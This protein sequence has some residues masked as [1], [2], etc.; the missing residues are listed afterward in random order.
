MISIINQAIMKLND[1]HLLGFYGELFATAAIAWIAF[2]L[3]QQRVAPAILFPLAIGGALGGV[4]LVLRHFTRV[5]RR[6]IAILSAIV[7]GL[8]LVVAQDYVGLRHRIRLFENE[9]AE[10]HPLAASMAKDRELRPT[11]IEHVTKHVNEYPVW[12][13]LDLLLTAAA[14]GGVMAWGTRA[15]PA[16]GSETPPDEK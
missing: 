1:R 7:W 10:S 14:A 8:V 6:W 11:L 4:L 13:T 5:P 3:Q 15:E 16:T 2:Q 9:L 12:W